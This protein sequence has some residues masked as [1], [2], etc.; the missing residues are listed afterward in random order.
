MIRHRVSGRLPGATSSR[1]PRR[2]LRQVLTALTAAAVVAALAPLGAT[3]AQAAPTASIS[4]TVTNAAGQPVAA[5]LWLAPEAGGRGFEA[6]TDAAGSFSISGF[7]GG[8]WNLRA[9]ETSDEHL[10]DAA[11]WDG[12]ASTSQY[13]SFPVADGAALTG[14]DLVLADATGIRVL[15]TDEAGNPLPNIQYGLDVYRPEEGDWWGLQRGP[16]L[17]R[18][19]GYMWENTV[20]GST[21]RLCFSDDYYQDDW[22]QP[23][24][25]HGDACV[26]GGTTFDD[27]ATFTVTEAT[28]RQEL[29]ITLPVVGQSLRPAEPFVTGSL[30]VGGTLTAETGTWKPAG[31]ALTYQWV[32][33]ADGGRV[34]CRTAP[35]RP[36]RRRP[37]SSARR[38]S[39]RS[40]ARSPATAPPPCRPGRATW[41]P[42]SRR[43]PSR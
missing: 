29:T 27:A 36:S 24:V 6:T 43:S 25:R 38:S 21:Y 5:T 23:A 39:S 35:A 22:Y 37:T 3:A 26:G 2:S 41:A 13:V 4:G 20:V 42:R 9:S 14:V 40:P 7:E 33:W 12:T 34:A 16:N 15:V 32:T 18:E 8:R 17:T 28:R 31:V 10:Y 1:A 19:N 30:A 11:F